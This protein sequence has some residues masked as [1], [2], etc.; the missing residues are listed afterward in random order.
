MNPKVQMLTGILLG[1]VLLIEGPSL[2]TAPCGPAPTRA[3]GFLRGITILIEAPLL[4]LRGLERP[5][6]EPKLG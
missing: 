6:E 2:F 3:F 4:L 1:V 5:P